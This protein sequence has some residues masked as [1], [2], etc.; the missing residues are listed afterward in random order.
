MAAI[1]SF[2]SLNPYIVKGSPAVGLGMVF[3][4]LTTQSNDEPFS[5]YG[6]LA[7]SI[8]MPEDRSW[9]AFKL[10][11][12]ARW[13]DGQPVT[14]DD[15]IFSFETLKA[16][17]PPFYRAY[18]ANVVKAERDGERRVKFAFDGPATASCR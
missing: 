7:E 1:G 16:K 15:V 14:V 8:E 17:G 10:R 13:H 9:V 5:E 18:Y 4:T 2:D 3:E 12:Q 11:P 6:L